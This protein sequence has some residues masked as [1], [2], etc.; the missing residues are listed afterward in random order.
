MTGRIRIGVGPLDARVPRYG[1][2]SLDAALDGL[3]WGD[4]VVWIVDDDSSAVDVLLAHVAESADCTD[5]TATEFSS[6]VFDLRAPVSRDAVDE[7]AR[8][9]LRDGRIAVWICPRTA[10]IDGLVQLAQVIVDVTES[11][12][13]IQRAD[14]RRNR[15]TGMEMHYTVR[16]GVADVGPPSTVS[17]LG[18][19]LRAIRKQR[20]WSQADLASMIGVSGS[21]ISQTERGQHSMSLD[22][23]I[24]LA[25]RLGVTVD[26]LVRGADRP[27]ELVRTP[28]SGFGAR[29]TTTAGRAQPIRVR[30]GS[31]MSMASDSAGAL[32]IL[33]GS[34]I[35]LLSFAD[36]S[37]VLRPGD[38]VETT[39][40]KVRTCRNLQ[41]EHA[42][43]FVLGA[44]AA[45]TPAFD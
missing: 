13:R 27:Y 32:T 37:I 36:D 14:G 12:M 19:A 24:D 8:S 45:E 28:M 11:R 38:I 31:T 20:G 5:V 10:S 41:P 22:T 17:R 16:D 21:A 40:S 15:I 6:A 26:R 25:E 34:G 7:A 44:P 43:L 1:L 39:A 42:L 18:E 23:V 29:S 9:V 35:V 3:W 2:D 4:N 33:V 30:P